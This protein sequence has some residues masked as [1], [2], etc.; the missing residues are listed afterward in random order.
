MSKIGGTPVSVRWATPKKGD[1]KNP[2]VP[3][4]VLARQIVE[5]HDGKG[6]RELF[7]ARPSL[8]M[9]KYVFAREVQREM[10]VHGSRFGRRE[11]LGSR[12]LKGHSAIRHLLFIDVSKVH[13]LC[14]SGS[15][16]WSIRQS[17]PR[18]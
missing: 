11:D 15:G 14:S 12:P 7:A 13:L 6:L 10:V 2:F 8:A 3:V 1:P 16:C 5:K 18:V 9:I 4:R 17:S